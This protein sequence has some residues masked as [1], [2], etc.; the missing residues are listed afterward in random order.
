MP[1]T[2]YK[3]DSFA[4][5]LDLVERFIKETFILKK[6][7]FVGTVGEMFDK[8][9]SF[10]ISK[11]SNEWGKIKFTKRLDELHIKYFKSNDKNKYN[12][13]LD[14]LIKIANSRHWIHELDEFTEVKDKNIHCPDPEG[15]DSNT[16]MSKIILENNSLKKQLEEM[17]K[18]LDLYKPKQ[19]D[20]E[21]ELES[22]IDNI[23]FISSDEEEE[24]EDFYK[25]MQSSSVIE[26]KKYHKGVKNMKNH[27][28]C[29]DD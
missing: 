10:S 27:L 20:S 28:S 5:R 8:F 15:I 11:N 9:N 18:L 23:N 29:L 2:K 16:A 13:K 6:K 12:T 22:D 21:S 3:L 1:L 19:Q 14:E 17:Q 25:A 24:E 26:I 4:K 7:D